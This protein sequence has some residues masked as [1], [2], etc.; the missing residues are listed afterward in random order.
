MSSV[1][2]SSSPIEPVQ[3]AVRGMTCA[4]CVGRV[5]RAL[6]KVPGVQEAQVNFATETASVTLSPE[7]CDLDPTGLVSAVEDAGYHA[8]IQQ[9]D[10]PVVEAVV[11]W[12]DVWGAV[13]LGAAASLP[14]LLPMLWGAH[15][16]W[17][18]WVQFALATP[19]Q[20][21]LGARFYKAGW[22]ALKDGSGNM[23]QLVALGT[24]AAWGLSC[25]L[26]WTHAQSV[27]AAHGGPDLY[28]ES[29]AVVITL[30]LLGKALEARA[31]RQTTAAIRALQALRPDTVSRLGP[32]G[33]VTVPLSQ[34]LVGDTLVVR[35]G[36]RIPTDGTVTEGA[37][38]VDEAMLTGEPLP[39]AKNQGDRLT[40]GAVNGEGRLVMLVTAVGGQTMLAHIIRRV[41][42]AQATKAPI[43]RVVDRV[44][45]V[46]VP[47]V[48]LVALL[49]G[50]GWWWSGAGGEVALIRAVAVLV[51]ACPCALG[52]ATPAAIMAG[53]GAAARQG[54]LIKDPEALETAHR[55]QVV[56]FDKTG[57]LTQGHPRLI[58]WQVAHEPAALGV[59]WGKPQALQV[60]AAL[61]AGSEH[62]LARAVLE[63]VEGAPRFVAQAVQSMPGR[64]V[65]GRLSEAGGQVELLGDWG[66]GS[67]R[68][69][70]E[71]ACAVEPS[72]R[73]QADA[74]ATSGATVSWLMRQAAAPAGG[75][76]VW[77]VMAAMAFGDEL[78]PGAAEAVARL[79]A[80]NVRTVMISGDNRGAAQAM[81]SRLGI[82]Q[83][84]AEVLPGDK[85]DH[86]QHLRQGEGGARLTVAMVGDGLNDAPAL[87]AADVGMAMANPEGGTDVALQAAGITLM[88]GDPM[89]VPAA[90]DISRRTSTKI[91]QNLAWAFGYNVIGIPLAAFGGLNPMLAGAA[92]A[93]S[94]VSVVTNALW[95]SRW[96][97]ARIA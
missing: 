85:A 7:A 95:L 19:V 65:V 81:A 71:Q 35:P 78:K 66:L 20:F 61:Q 30:V 14:L 83:V 77:Q 42:D 3:L 13:I 72:L 76:P 79:H 41:V 96:K 84:V 48:L 86:I 63:A 53:T 54:I 75:E 91:W 15:H 56:A 9:P 50:L 27:H 46:F 43:Q 32:Q 47:T 31:K 16:F 58:E 36:E 67:A 70:E 93:L 10:A 59:A 1:S 23:D 34:V 22:A 80:L 88:R 94:S 90:L 97:P 37:S 18:A 64:G 38:H 11:P 57:T 68:W 89:L 62:P 87:A 74:W 40:G 12:W 49:T 4:A 26:W 82:Q 45:A 69:V 29:S 6:R 51:I 44:S 5:E 39:V 33:E 55:V 17:P 52:L 73:V 92:M 21:G 25:W 28:F 24:S 60:A 8:L 2:V